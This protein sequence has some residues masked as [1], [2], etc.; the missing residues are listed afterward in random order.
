MRHHLASA[1]KLC[2]EGDYIQAAEKT[3]G[4]LSAAINAK[5]SGPEKKTWSEKRTA[6]IELLI[7]CL[8]SYPEL[9]TEMNGL[10]FL[11]THDVFNAA[12]GLHKYFYGGTNYTDSQVA[13]RV[14]FLTKIIGMI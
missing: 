5:R 8:K 7:E 4:A 10:G 11:T 13:D 3:W 2:E 12:Y 6:F 1:A 9:R 14:T